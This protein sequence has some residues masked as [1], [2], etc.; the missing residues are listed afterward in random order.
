MPMVVGDCPGFLVNRLMYFYGNEAMTLLE[1]G[2]AP[3][4]ID[5]AAV[6]FGMPMGPVALKDLVGLD[7]SCY[8]ARTMCQAYADRARPIRIL[9]EM[10]QAGRLGQ[11]SGAGFYRYP[12]RYRGED[13]PALDPILDRCRPGRR[14]MS[15]EEIT[16]RLFLPMLVE[17]TRV[18]MEGIVHEP[19]DV[20]MG[21][22]LGVGFPAYRGGL[23]RWADS[24]GLEEVLRRLQRY[25]HLGPRFHP[26]DL[27]R[28]L[29]SQGK[30]FYKS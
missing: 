19:G 29:A 18:L 11:K 14:T 1:E 13:D 26:T 23:L 9:E 28:D 24:L 12:K 7:T 20:D 22:I 2:V 30:G 16:D 25:E 17:A 5:R 27:L 3:R 6:A 21:L 10:V 4:D 8:T 15:Q